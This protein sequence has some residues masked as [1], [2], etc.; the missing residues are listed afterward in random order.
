MMRLL[1]W[2]PCFSQE[3]RAHHEQYRL[4]TKAVIE[5]NENKIN[6][7]D[8]CLKENWDHLFLFSNI[9]FVIKRL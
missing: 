5:R 7:F 6:E 1:I 3:S 2:K 4:L 8:Q 9:V